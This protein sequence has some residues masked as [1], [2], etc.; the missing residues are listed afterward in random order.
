MDGREISNIVHAGVVFGV[1]LFI[2]ILIYLT[3]SS[4]IDSV[5]DAIQA[6]PPDDA[7]DEMA[8]HAP[9]IE[10]GIKAAFACGFAIPIT[11]FVFWV[12]SKEPFIGYRRRY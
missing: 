7:A 2:M 12:M 10:W 4:P 5:M 6:N 8:E 9:N 3:L 1:Y 11:W